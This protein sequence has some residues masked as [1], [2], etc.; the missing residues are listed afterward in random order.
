M[1]AGR[2][3]LPARLAL[4]RART[5]YAAADTHF[6]NSYG[7]M[8]VCASVCASVLLPHLGRPC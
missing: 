7:A 5:L 3:T 6:H 2:P 8:Y 4:L 1:Q